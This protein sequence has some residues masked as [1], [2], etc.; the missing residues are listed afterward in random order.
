MAQRYYYHYR[1]QVYGPFTP[2][3][4]QDAPLTG[5]TPICTEDKPQFYPLRQWPELVPLLNAEVSAG[6]APH[7]SDAGAS[8]ALTPPPVGVLGWSFFYFSAS[9]AVGYC[10]V[11]AVMALSDPL[12]IFWGGFLSLLLL[13]AGVRLQGFAWQAVRPRLARRRFS[14]LLLSQ[15]LP[16]AGGIVFADQGMRHALHYAQRLSPRAAPP[17]AFLRR[18]RILPPLLMGCLLSAWGVVA[19]LA[20]EGLYDGILMTDYLALNYHWLTQPWIQWGGA[21]L[22]LLVWA[23]GTWRQCRFLPQAQQR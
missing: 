13:L 3:E 19:Y 9:L 22:A 23:A 7:Q 10:S 4:L 21:A 15:A 1:R 17:E 11:A 16:V 6:A 2:A 8:P 18:Q 5:D 12:S 14:L 20:L